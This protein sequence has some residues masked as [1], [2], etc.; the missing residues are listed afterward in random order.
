M[1]VLTLFATNNLAGAAQQEMSE[2][3]PGAEVYCATGPWGWVVGNSVNVTPDCANSDAQTEVARTVFVSGDR[4]TALV[5]T[6][7]A[8]NCLRTTNTYNGSFAN[9]N[10][11]MH[12]VVRA[13]T[14]G[15]TATGAIRFRLA[16][17]TDPAGVG[18][19]LIDATTRVGSTVGPILVSPSYDSTLTFNPG[20]VTLTDE[21]LFA[22]LAWQRVAA[23]GGT[24]ND[25]NVRIGDTGTRLITADF[26]AVAVPD[27]TAAVRRMA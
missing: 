20:I 3:S 11:A 13:N 24:T 16:R 27:V 7:G 9:A 23:G 10:W 12:F 26:T 15:S 4:P 14:A 25:V 2:V 8:G 18:A 6:A 5:T 17:G 19:T 21:Y 1:A 22:L